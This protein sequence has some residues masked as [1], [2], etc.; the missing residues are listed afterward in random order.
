MLLGQI[1]LYLTAGFTLLSLFFFWF[2]LKSN[3]QLRLA[4][5]TF[6][7]AT[8]FCTIAVILLFYAF[9]T[10]KFQLSYV[11]GY[12]SSDLPLF[13]LI[14]SFWA[15]QEGSFLL[16]LFMGFVLGLFVLKSARENQAPVLFYYLIAQVFI[17]FM[18]LKKSPFELMPNIPVE[19][20]GL[21]PLLQDPWMVIHPPLVFLGYAALTVPFTFALAAL[22]KNSFDTWHKQAFP[23]TSFSVLSLGAGIFVGGFWA[24][25]VLGWG[26]YWG[27]DPV[28]NASLIPWL[29]SLA[30]VHGLILERAQGSLRKTN[31]LLAII[32]FL[33]VV[34]GTFL[35][36][37]GVLADFS[38]HSFADLGINKYLVFFMLLFLGISLGLMLSRFPKIKTQK[39]APDPISQQ[40]FLVYGIWI[41]GILAF[42]I[43]LGTS[44]PLLTTLAGNPSNVAISYY[45]KISL[46]LAVLLVLFLSFSP[47]LDWQKTDLKLLQKNLLFPLLAAVVLTVFALLWGV[48]NPGHLLLIFLTLWALSS[49]LIRFFRKLPEG[50]GRASG[51]LTHIGFALLILG[52]IFSSGYSKSQR[53]P[54]TKDKPEKIEDFQLTFQGEIQES[55]KQNSVSLILAKGGNSKELKP[56]L[57]FSEYTQ[58]QMRKPYIQRGLTSDLY[59]APLE[60]RKSTSGHF[61]TSLILTKGETV[62]ISGFQVTFTE[63]EMEPHMQGGEMRNGARREGAQ[64]ENRQTLTPYLIAGGEQVSHQDVVF[65]DGSTGLTLERIMADTRQIGV[66]VHTEVATAELTET[67]LLEVSHKPLINLLWLGGVLVMLG[68]LFSIF[69][70]SR[71]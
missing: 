71:E 7:G 55:N 51:F 43:L 53:I 65:P 12:S 48:K 64:G 26:G 44:A 3:R 52:V 24:Y 29:T 70:R 4:R 1:S 34:Y 60:L 38:V 42:L 18:L 45:V 69:R 5:L 2:S 30:L 15:G 11:F 6:W 21:N 17:L 20:R 37:S 59:L 67:L 54:L 36:R 39:T 49:N 9:L 47:L 28:E 23:W 56:R 66:I 8:L 14:S 50:L 40:K 10:H 13:Y 63:F 46:P 31:L 57:Y 41:L 61:D 58:E 32:S 35:T 33:L 16:W 62:T 19:G 27:W 68:S 22:H 25:K